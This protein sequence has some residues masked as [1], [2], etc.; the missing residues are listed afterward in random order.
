MLYLVGQIFFILL[1][2][3]AAGLLTG[4]WFRGLVTEV[5]HETV[6]DEPGSDPFGARSRLE[7]C[8]RD[9]AALRRD[10]KQSQDE[11]EHLKRIGQLALDEDIME[12]LGA[13][14]AR[15]DALL[16]DLQQRDDTIA[17]LEKELVQLRG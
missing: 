13:A 8:H 7:Q 11:L 12:R 4:W 2:A 10:L 16:Q 14:E 1:L 15:V 9:N 5:R 3:V 6:P 17:V